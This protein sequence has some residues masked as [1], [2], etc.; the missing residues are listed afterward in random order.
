VKSDECGDEIGL[1]ASTAK[2]RKR[3]ADALR[4]AARVSYP[5]YKLFLKEHDILSTVTMTPRAAPPPKPNAPAAKME[6]PPPPLL[7]EE[8]DVQGHQLDPGTRQ[9]FD[10]K[11]TPILRNP[12]GKLVNVEGG[13]V[14][15]TAPRFGPDGEQLDAFNRPLPPGAV[16]MFTADGTPIGVG[17][18]G[19]HYLPDGTIV[20][21]TDAHFDASGNQLAQEVV[22]AANAVS[23]NVSVA[24]KVRAKLKGDNAKGEAV[25]VLGRTFRGVEGE[26]GKLI[27]AD[28]EAVP[29][30]SARMVQGT[31]GK[32][33]QYT[34]K[35][36][37]TNEKHSL[38]IKVEQGEAEIELGSVEIGATTSLKEV[39]DRIHSELHTSLPDFVFLFNA[40]A[41]LKYEEADRLAVN[42]L[43]EIIIRGKELKAMEPPKSKFAKKLT[44]LSEYEDQKKKEQD[45]FNDI[46]NRVRQG[47]FL[48]Q[49]K[50][51]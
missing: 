27:N 18:D 28:G 51:E 34:E 26:G 8:F 35:K 50:A 6:A 44:Q 15:P 23:T 46:M 13:F 22:E 48:K 49:T 3:W 47:K 45:E 21:Q 30:A 17:P 5:D 4:V 40:V 12:E 20:L 11:G 29:M 43:P 16:P 1:V 33:V 42:S 14:K 7:T 9:A 36:P 37:E 10:E 19:V 31:T 25:D 39:R 38:L 24:I 2:V 41:L 32:L